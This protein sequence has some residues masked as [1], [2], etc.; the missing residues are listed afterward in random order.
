MGIRKN[1]IPNRAQEPVFDLAIAR[2]GLTLL[3]V[4]FDF[5]LTL[6]CHPEEAESH[7]KRATPNEGPMQLARSGSTD[8]IRLC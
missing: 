4:A 3:S 8:A 6:R 5:A 1:V 2:L 7:A